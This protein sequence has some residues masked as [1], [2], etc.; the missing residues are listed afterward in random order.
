[1]RLPENIVRRGGTYQFRIDIPADC[2]G[3]PPF[4][5]AKEWKR[6]LKTNDLREA[7]ERA[8][9]TRIQFH[10]M[11]R[12][13]RAEQDPRVIAAKRTGGWV[14]DAL[15]GEFIS[16]NASREEIAAKTEAALA[17]F[18]EKLAED[19]WQVL[20]YREIYSEE[21]ADV[22]VEEL[23]VPLA[24][25]DPMVAALRRALEVERAELAPL[26]L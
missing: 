10:K 22:D 1:M 6:S 21:H 13:A 17:V 20:L 14:V 7:T 8:A 15:A 3:R 4:G 2:Q 19:D 26:R 12:E 18:R 9:R 16:P 5:K 25:A 24:Y 11:C 23:P